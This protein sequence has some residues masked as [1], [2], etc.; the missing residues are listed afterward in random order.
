MS[1]ET[2]QWLNNNVL[3]G[4]T[5]KRGKAW[6]YRQSEQGTE[7]N[8]YPMAIPAADVSRRLFKWEPMIVPVCIPV[9]GEYIEIDGKNAI[10]PSDDPSHVFGIF[11]NDYQPHGYDEWLIGNVSNILGDTLSISSAGLLK[12]RGVAWVEVSVPDTITTPEGIAFRPNLLA[13]TSLDGTVATTYK[14]TC[15]FTVCDNTWGMAMAEKGQTYK[16]K[17]T[18]YSAGKIEQ[19]KAREALNLIQET[20]DA[21]QDELRALCQIE[22]T[23]DEFHAIIK[24]VTDPEKGKEQTKTGATVQARK[25]AEITSLYTSDPRVA[26]W[27]NTAF[28]VIQ[29]F[30]TW[31]H[32]VKPTRGDTER[33]ERNALASIKGETEKSDAKV[34]AA[35]RKELALT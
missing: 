23:R 32:H 33:A 5:E 16:R 24:T 3:I 26:P 22:V 29:A 21:V 2:A 8:H 25:V 20:S 15:T 4:F 17:H 31:E 11:S 34:W 13:T 30:N 19:D 28:G 35:I 27:T 6:H 14:R 9:D 10:V 12:G 7:P 1:K 18:R